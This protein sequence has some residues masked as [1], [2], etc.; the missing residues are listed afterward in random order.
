VRPWLER[1]AALL[2]ADATWA[3]PVVVFSAWQ[4]AV[5]LRTGSLP[6][7]SPTGNNAAAPFSGLVD[8]IV[9]YVAL[10]PHKAALEWG[11][12]C[13][14]LAL[15]GALAAVSLRTSRAM[16]HERIAWVFSLVFVVLLSSSVWLGDV[17]FRSLDDFYLLSGVLVLFSRVRLNAAGWLVAVTWSAVAV[18]LILLI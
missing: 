16:L 9:H 10:F 4:L 14:V 3:L 17:G 6:M 11:W 18:E 2:T 8:G 12:E 7:L 13:A 15:F 5:L 1:R